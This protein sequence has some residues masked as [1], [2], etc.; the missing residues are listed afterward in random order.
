MKNLLADTGLWYALF[1]PRDSYYSIARDKA[2]VLD[3]ARVV[4]PWPILYETLCTRF[5]RNSRSLA[6]FEQLLKKSNFV[7]LDDSAYRDAACQLSFDSSLRQTRP[8]SLVD[9]AIRLILD[10]TNTKIDS[11]LTF[12][13]KDFSDVCRRRDIEMF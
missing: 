4:V 13:P 10:D 6:T 12:N 11:F 7:Q 3:V 9:C 5:V 2:H 1:D 8:L